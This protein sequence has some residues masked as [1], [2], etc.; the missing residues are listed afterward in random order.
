MSKAATSSDQ[1]S[2]QIALRRVLEHAADPAWLADNSPLAT[3]YFLGARLS[4][5]EKPGNAGA[6]L[7]LQSLLHETAD[8][9]WGAHPP[10]TRA[11]LVAAVDEARQ[12]QGNTGDEYA[13]LILELRYFRRYFMPGDYP[14]EPADIPQYLAVSSTRFYVHLNE[15]I[16]R[17]GRLLLHHVQPALRP[18]RPLQPET[19]VARE[20]EVRDLSAAL[21]AGHS[22]SLTGP[23]GA[24]KT[25]LGAVIAHQRSDPVFWLTFLPGLNDTLS[26]VLYALA[27]YTRDRG[28]TALWAYLAANSG[29]APEPARAA[30]LL[31]ADV[32]ALGTPTPLLVFDEVDLLRTTDSQPRSGAHSQLLFFLE[33]LVVHAT[34]LLIGQRTY[35]DTPVH[36]S[37]VALDENG[38]TALL[39]AAG[40]P[41]P[42]AEVR[43]VREVTGGL[44][45]LVWLV[46]ALLRSGEELDAMTQLPLRGDATP[47]FHRLW[48]RLDMDEKELLMALS[49]FRRAAPDDLWA[50][51]KMAG[52]SLKER[53]LL[54]PGG[55]G[56][57]ALQPFF[58]RL[59]YQELRPEQREKFHHYAGRVRAERGDYTAAAYHLVQAGEP[60]LAVGVWFP[61]RE[62]E[63]GRGQ[64]GAAEEIFS[65]LSTRNLSTKAIRHLRVIQNKLYLMAGETALVTDNVRSITWDVDDA[66]TAEAYSQAATA[67]GSAGDFDGAL[68]YHA[69]AL[70]V[71]GRLVAA[72]IDV[73]SQ[74]GNI[75]F[76]Q[77]ELAQARMEMLR[78]E[79]MLLLF[80]G[81]IEYF[82][83]RYDLATTIFL[84]ALKIAETLNDA[85]LAAQ[86]N[87]RL[88]EVYSS[89]G[90]VEAAEHALE[91]A[92]A[93]HE[94]IGDRL[95]SEYLRVTLGSVYINARMYPEA[96][97]PTERALAFLEQTG[98]TEWTSQPLVQ[99]AEAY[100][101]TGRTE[102]AVQCAIRVLNL[103]SPLYRPYA[104]YTLGLARQRQG[105]L[106]SAWEAYSE[107]L[108]TARRN[109]DRLIEAYL[110]RNIGRMEMKEGDSPA[111]REALAAALALFSTMNIAREIAET[112]QDLA[113]LG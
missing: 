37:L 89:L 112:E 42:A 107:G 103:D 35:L 60:E 48:R 26:A 57:I 93:H 51:H 47:L 62:L 8:S 23:P 78:A 84:R 79:N 109:N 44:P 110:Q 32:A 49:T 7:A 67:A 21:L 25:T 38:V 82:A 104:L 28:Q 19:F 91:Q 95:V 14:I 68:D 20:R 1:D 92:I 63:I 70:E 29:E 80:T 100:L 66:L 43:R 9:L 16:D 39:Q 46:V 69:Q 17:L 86:A 90:Q 72:I 22:V 52:N 50:S 81:R 59:V 10:P 55:P 108:G 113:S 36:L 30:G 65:H 102:E 56:E 97:P 76:E 53:R 24:G 11:A 41:L 73:H 105:Q 83:N 96:I 111:A 98:Q 40:T 13:Y 88:A 101:E 33:S 54:E 6:G 12:L 94:Q 85:G 4:I 27:H 71:L 106:E 77:G 61:Q 34:L 64:A 45:R 3:P 75:F 74:R 2:F 99:L 18:E 31:R 58:Q 5:D 15:A 87:R